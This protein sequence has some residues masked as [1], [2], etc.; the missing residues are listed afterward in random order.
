MMVGGILAYLPIR[1]RIRPR[2]PLQHSTL[3]GPPMLLFLSNRVLVGGEPLVVSGGELV[4]VVDASFELGEAGWVGLEGC[5][6][7]SER[8]RGVLA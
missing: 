2:H 7:L 6:G 1:Q 4:V 8:G 5:G 3:D